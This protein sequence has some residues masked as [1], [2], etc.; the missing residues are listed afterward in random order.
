MCVY[1]AVPFVFLCRFLRNKRRR[2]RRWWW[3]WIRKYAV[4]F[5]GWSNSKNHPSFLSGTVTYGA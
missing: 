2:R 4:I 1:F 5:S 3:W